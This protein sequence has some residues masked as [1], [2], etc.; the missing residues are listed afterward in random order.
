MDP[1]L[2]YGVPQG[3][4]FG[5][6]VA[7]EWSGLRYRL[8]RV[9]MPA[10]VSSETY[11]RVNAVGETPS[12]MAADGRV[13]SQSMAILHHI[14]AASPGKELGFAQGTPAFDRFNEVL[15]FLNTGFFDSFSTLWYALEQGGEGAENQVLT[16]V[17]R[18]KVRKAHADLESMLGNSEWLAGEHRTAVDAYFM[19]IARWNDYHQV[20]DRRDYP[21]LHRLHTRLA[22]DRAV[23]FAHAVEEG[24]EAPHGPGF[25]G[26][27]S[28]QEALQR[29]QE[30][31]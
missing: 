2:F 16:D 12:W 9:E 4:S 6:I 17:G 29:V 23:L 5:S 31:A 26:H 15:A 13:F 18:K 3:C 22:S 19:G 20:L 8:C 25:Q 14:A 24:R 11:R 21:G 30:A 7:L 1:I 27:A 28:L 10:V